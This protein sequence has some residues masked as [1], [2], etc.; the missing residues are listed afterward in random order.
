[1]NIPDVGNFY[2]KTE[3]NQEIWE[4]QDT[5]SLR[6]RYLLQKIF[7]IHFLLYLEQKVKDNSDLTHLCALCIDKMT[8][9]GCIFLLTVY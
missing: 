2:I 6:R 4:I 5:F 9:S 3:E 1:M 8:S 7:Y